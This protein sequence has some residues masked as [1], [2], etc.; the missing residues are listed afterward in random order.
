MLKK[1]FMLL[2]RTQE[3]LIFYVKLSDNGRALQHFSFLRNTLL[4]LPF[5]NDHSKASIQW[6]DETQYKLWR[7]NVVLLKR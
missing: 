4:K 7:D 5:R 6:K 2:L 1:Q 3:M